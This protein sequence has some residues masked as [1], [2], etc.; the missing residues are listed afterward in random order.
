[1]SAI[2]KKMIIRICCRDFF[3]MI[4]VTVCFIGL[5]WMTTC[6]FNWE[7]RSLSVFLNDR[8]IMSAFGGG[9]SAIVINY[10]TQYAINQIRYGAVRR[11]MYQIS[12]VCTA[13][14]T[15]LE[16][17]VIYL[18]VL[19]I[20]HAQQVQMVEN[21]FI[22]LVYIWTVF[23]IYITK[24]KILLQRQKNKGLIGVGAVIA[25]MTAAIIIVA[26]WDMCIKGSIVIKGSGEMVSPLL[27]WGITVILGIAIVSFCIWYIRRQ[28]RMIHAYYMNVEVI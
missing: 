9:I 21:K 5:L 14:T 1:M 23:V 17:L 4:G 19:L 27:T 13:V 8:S 24:N 20:Y 6:L 3:I 12:K 10:N 18:V 11:E 26:S 28:L 7:L 2:A 15:V 25:A 22:I 16:T